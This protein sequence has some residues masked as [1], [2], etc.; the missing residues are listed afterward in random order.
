MGVKQ[1]SNGKIEMLIFFK[2]CPYLPHSS[3]CGLVGNQKVL[4]EKHVLKFFTFIGIGIPAVSIVFLKV[5]RI[6]KL[7]Q[8]CVY[9]KLFYRRRCNEI[10]FPVEITSQWILNFFRMKINYDLNFSIKLQKRYITNYKNVLLIGKN[11]KDI[12]YI[13]PIIFFSMSLFPTFQSELNSL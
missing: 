6:K 9:H 13:M 1:L 10:Y 11:E 4:I 8:I 3:N 7:M 12:S 2:R 5:Q